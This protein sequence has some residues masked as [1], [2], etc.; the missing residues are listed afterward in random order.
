MQKRVEIDGSAYLIDQLPAKA[1]LQCALVRGKHM[2]AILGAVGGAGDS[3]VAMA[4]AG[5]A[6]L[7]QMML[8]ADYMDACWSPLLATMSHADGRRL[9]ETWQVEFAGDKL[10][11]LFR[12]HEAAMQHS[13]GAFLAGLQGVLANATNPRTTAG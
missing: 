6:A 12:L 5:I 3:E 13:C 10:G 7:C 8:S 4:G 1:A 2:G 11:V 9:A